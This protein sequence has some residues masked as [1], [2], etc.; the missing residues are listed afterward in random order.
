M[1]SVKLNLETCTKYARNSRRRKHKLLEFF[2]R[3]QTHQ[4]F[5]NRL[6][7]QDKCVFFLLT[8]QAQ[9]VLILIK[10]IYLTNKS[11]DNINVF[12]YC[13]GTE[14]W[15]HENTRFGDE[16]LYLFI[17]YN[18]TYQLKSNNGIDI[19]YDKNINIS[20]FFEALSQKRSFMSDNN[21]TCSGCS[22]FR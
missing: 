17:Y 9:K 6:I 7:F 13:T 5:E 4:L 12:W 11:I 21:K 14:Q 22:T 8:I 18:K 19:Y 16:T 3:D 15:M 2:S 1:K 10:H 20:G